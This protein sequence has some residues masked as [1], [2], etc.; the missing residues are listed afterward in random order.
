MALLAEEL[1]HPSQSIPFLE[2][3]E[4]SA[5]KVEDLGNSLQKASI[6]MGVLGVVCF[7]VAAVSFF[8]NSV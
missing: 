4:K 6:G 2:L 8:S 3:F 7:G 5:K 1:E